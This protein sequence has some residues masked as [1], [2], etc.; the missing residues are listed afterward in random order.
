[1]H[2]VS[3]PSLARRGMGRFARFCTVGAS[4]VVV[5]LS[6]LWFAREHLLS[7]VVSS[8]VRLN[9]ALGLAILLATVNNFY[10]NR[11]WTWRDRRPMSPRTAA[12]FGQY[13]LAV[14]LGSS[15]Q[16]L[17]TNGLARIMHYL[18]ANALSIAAAAFVNFVLNDA[19]TFRARSHR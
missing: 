13:A 6:V 3:T 8:T 14:A 7:R 10:W 5:N 2:G 11:H 9:V 1:M 19:W 18:V 12:Q 4:G 16:V 17:L 15:V